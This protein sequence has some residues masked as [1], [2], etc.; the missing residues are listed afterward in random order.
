LLVA[1]DLLNA[2]VVDNELI[3]E[4]KQTFGAQETVK[5]AVL[6]GGSRSPAFPKSSV[7]HDRHCIFAVR[8]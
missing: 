5:G 4:F 2:R 8:I 3:N 1:C 6:Y 7:A